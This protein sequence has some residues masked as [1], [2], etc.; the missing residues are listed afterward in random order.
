MS[1]AFTPGLQ[2]SSAAQVTKVRE[3]P[4]PGEILVKVG[5]EVQSSQTVARAVLP[6]DLAIVRVAERM[7]IEPF[8]VIKGLKV[9]VGDRISRDQLLCEH[10][11][12]FGLLKSRF[13]SLHAGSVEF[14]SEPT[15]HLGVRG[16]P[17]IISLNAYI[18]G[19]VAS[20]Q[21]K[22]S[23]TITSKAAL[24]QGI[25]GVGGERQGVIQCL[26]VNPD[27]LLEPVDI[28]TNV[29]GKILIGGTKPSKEAISRASELGA[30][31]LVVGSIDDQALKDYLGYDL[32]IAL[33]GDEK[34]PMTLIITEGFGYIPF[35]QRTFELL[36]T[37]DGCP[38]SINGATQVR[39]GALRPEIISPHTHDIPISVKEESQGLAVGRQIRI[40]RVPYFG[41]L[42]T[43][44]ELPREIHQIETGAEA[45]VLK[46]RLN[47]GREVIVPRANVEV[48]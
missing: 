5:E 20:I 44:T 38:A 2:I 42:A 29:A 26:A 27:K 46:A 21:P 23:V 17:R 24:V 33:T 15:G 6:G 28:P 10:A 13:Y 1:Q 32:G 9:K 4:I 8:E 25:F 37:L 40:I 45:R 36:K 35:S 11:G 43:V 48:A 14:I 34:I 18:S 3:L 16:E 30:L 39:A 12:L 31:G 47:D 22:K 41:A 7:G 19:V